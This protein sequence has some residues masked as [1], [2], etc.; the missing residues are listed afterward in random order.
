M[1]IF[2]DGRIEDPKRS[3][4]RTIGI[5][6][7]REGGLVSPFV[8]SKRF[9]FVVTQNIQLGSCGFEVC[10]SLFQLDQLGAAR[11]SPNSRSRKDQHHRFSF[12]IRVQVE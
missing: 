8:V 12:A 5:R 3:Y 1:I 2:F 10:H 6:E 4:D 11:R 9:N 7:H